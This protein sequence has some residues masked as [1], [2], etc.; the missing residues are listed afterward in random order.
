MF[1]C[2]G[3]YFNILSL[4]RIHIQHSTRNNHNENS[5][6]GN[7]SHGQDPK[8][9]GAYKGSLCTCTLQ[10]TRVLG[11]TICRMQ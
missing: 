2:T 1:S 6:M 10:F 9:L 3:L 7:G 5:G 4:S 11:N 8:E